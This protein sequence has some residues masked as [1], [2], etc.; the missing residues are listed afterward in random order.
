ARAIGRNLSA[1]AYLGRVNGLRDGRTDVV[2]ATLARLTGSLPSNGVVEALGVANVQGDR[3]VVTAT[4][5][6][7][8]AALP[9]GLDV[10]AM[11]GQRQALDLARDGGTPSAAEPQDGA[12]PGQ[13]A[14][15]IAYPEYGSSS[16]PATTADR[17][18]QVKGY[19]VAVVTPKAAIENSL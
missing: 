6:A 19:L 5:P 17:R 11:P 8:S 1:T 4:V 16:V 2:S 14:A 9:V 7:G 18:A 10:A 13:P 3:T 12:F 15:L